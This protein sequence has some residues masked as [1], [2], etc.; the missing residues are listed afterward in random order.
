VTQVPAIAEDERALLQ[1]ARTGDRAAL[2]RLLDLHQSRVFRFSLRMCRVREDAEDV[3]QETLLA[4]ART[5]REFR[6]EASVSTWLYT[7]ARSF[8]IK[9]RRRSKFAP[10]PPLSIESDEGR[11]AARLVDGG[12]RPDELAQDRELRSALDEAITALPTG[13]RE[14]LLLRDVE[15]LPAAEV[16]EILGITEKAVKSRLH[17]ARTSVRDALSPLTRPR[18]E[19]AP[20]GPACPDVAALFS[21]S[22]EGEIGPEECRE[23][24]RHVAACPRCGAA[25]DALKATLG[26]CRTLPA[27]EVPPQL[28]AAIR[29]GIRQVIA[30]RA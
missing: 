20:A 10:D 8:C 30:G 14:V 16:A 28:Q 18:G 13:Y 22:L 26:M 3:L 25:C 21:R 11:E 27:P 15:G 1:A 6:G 29:D 12:R 19:L 4:V 5:V 2:D 24:E 9:K 17:R 23:M 7:I